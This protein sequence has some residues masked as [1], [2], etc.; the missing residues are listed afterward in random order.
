MSVRLLM[1]FALAV[2]FGYAEPLSAFG[3]GTAAP[4]RQQKRAVIRTE[5]NVPCEITLTER[6]EHG[7]PLQNVLLDVV[8]TDPAGVSRRVP[9]FWDGGSTW[10][11]RY[12][13][14]LLGQ[15][16]WR[17]ECSDTQDAGLHGVEGSVE[18]GKYRGDNPLFRHGPV[19]VA[20]D[21]RHFEYT[22]GKPFFWLGDTWWMGLSDRLHWPDEFA[23]LTE[24]RKSKGFNVVQIVAGLYPDM[25]PF[26][27]RGANEGGYP[28]K[29]NYAALRPEYF[30]AADRRLRYLVD[31][32][33]TPCIVGAWGYF[34]PW[35]GQERMEKHWRNLIARYG[36]W[37]VVWCAAGEAN[38]PWY[39]AP[40]FPYDDRKQATD[41]TTIVRYIRT[42]DPFRRPLTIHPTAIDF[43][44]SRHA[45]DEPTL[46]D[47]DMLQTPHGQRE[48]VPITVGAVRSSLAAA[49]VMP[50]IDGEASYER[51][52]DSLPTE[53]TRAMFWLCLMNGA[54]GHTYGANGIWQL[55]RK[56][57]PHG[58]S[59]HGG[60]YGVIPWDEA[61]RLPGSAQVGYGRKF[62][63]S[64]PWTRLE[65]MPD[66]VAWES[67]PTP[68][69]P[70]DWI[71]FPEGDPK[72][73]APVASR[74]FRRVFVVPAPNTVRRARIMLSA[75]DKFT[76]WVNGKQIGSGAHWPVFVH[77]DITDA[78]RKGDNLIAIEAVNSAAP[79]A[80]NP[81][82]LSVGLDLE[83][84]DGAHQS[85]RSDNAWQSARVGTSGWN[86]LAFKAEDWSPAL[87]T[88]HFGDAP[89]G[90]PATEDSLFMPQSC[91]IGDSL[92]AIYLLTPGPI[93]VHK[94]RPQAE[95]R[96]VYFDPVSGRRTQGASIHTDAQ[97]DCHAEAPRTK[98]DWVILLT[99][100]EGKG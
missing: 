35:M 37:P 64:L 42:N 81:A 85:L 77:F 40:G 98:H 62:F 93:V 14:P 15:H 44:T 16:R 41:W 70:G 45:I 58:A 20:A 7:D 56:D 92:R 12:A 9:A 52:N 71:W 11:V 94:M 33:I 22:D 95:Y 75:D 88:A 63:E 80:L 91:G 66:T 79:V 86:T 43:Y 73:D 57:R 19:R 99:L 55:N 78:L 6:R 100:V 39:L 48:A 17:S 60:N 18:I 76:L 96:L 29:Q 82:G 61:M 38:L 50:V 54:K 34:L 72:R 69:T 2:V 8:F 97:G 27:P 13:S 84:T 47:F 30:D 25:F 46:L 36:A 51:L 24:D 31:Q 74:Y 53:W 26:D 67:S 23:E 32:G 49:P 87:V 3:Q 4:V 65:P 10:K 5:A 89:W 83:F 90:R 28:W 1:T 68:T 59:P 21:K